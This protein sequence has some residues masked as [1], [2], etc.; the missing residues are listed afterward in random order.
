MASTPFLLKNMEQK[1]LPSNISNEWWNKAMDE[2]IAPRLSKSTP[3][4]LGDNVFPTVGSRPAASIVGEGGQKP[5]SGIQIGAKTIRPI[6]AVVGVEVSEETVDEDP[7]GV[8]DLIESEMTA[9]LAR[10]I[11]LA[12]FHGREAATGNEITQLTD[13]IN[14]TTNRV[15]LAGQPSQELR[16]GH[17][18]QLAN[19]ENRM[20]GFNGFAFDPLMAATI[21]NERDKNGQLINPNMPLGSESI[22]NYAGVRT[23]VADAVSGQVDASGDTLVR[24]FGGNFDALRFGYNKSIWLEKIPYGDPFGNGDL[25]GRNMIAYLAEVRFGFAIMDLNAF[26]AYDDKV[27]NI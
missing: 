19:R 16:A 3:I 5:G 22:S 9:A 27:A 8:L 6:K 15:E 18:L 7:A 23:A 2:A 14:K 13:W 10:Q 25:R 11:D 12:V 4:T 17:M 20:R 21:G 24:A 1:L 26:V